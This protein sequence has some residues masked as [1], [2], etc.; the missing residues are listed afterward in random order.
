MPGSRSRLVAFSDVQL[1]VTDCPL[2]I[3]LG[4]AVR[5]T[6]GFAGGAA[7]GGGGGGGATAFLWQEAAKRTTPMV[8]TRSARLRFFCRI[9]RILL[10]QGT[11]AFPKNDQN[12]KPNRKTSKGLL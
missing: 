4:T 3:V 12:M 1:S 2:W 9:L 5:L 6:V 7:G 8:P 10:E 11:I